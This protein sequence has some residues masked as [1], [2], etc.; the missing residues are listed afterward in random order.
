[1]LYTLSVRYI[2]SGGE[3]DSCYTLYKLYFADVFIHM[4]AVIRAGRS[5]VVHTTT[6]SDG[7]KIALALV[8]CASEV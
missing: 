1:M 3:G 7:T 4:R 8:V 5:T 2:L 6:H